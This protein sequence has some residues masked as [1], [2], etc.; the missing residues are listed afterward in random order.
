M[1][2]SIS[3]KFM[4]ALSPLIVSEKHSIEK[5]KYRFDRNKYHSDSNKN[6]PRH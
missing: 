4:E 2:G 6:I 1:D 3:F 5:Q